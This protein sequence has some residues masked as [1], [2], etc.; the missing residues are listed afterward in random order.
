[1]TFLKWQRGA[2]SFSIAPS[3]ITAEF[4]IPEDDH[5]K[6]R[7]VFP[8][9]HIIRVLDEMPLST[10]AEETP[11]EGLVSEHFAYRVEGTRFWQ[12]QSDA[13]KLAHKKAQ[14]YRFITGG[15]CLDVIASCPPAMSVV[16]CDTA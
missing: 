11:N 2:P 10:E 6:L 5:H 13:F 16:I 8:E 15:N 12:I 14:H 9:V 1:M 4:I 3:G 7:V